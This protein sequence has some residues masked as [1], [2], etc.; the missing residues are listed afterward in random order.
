MH[1]ALAF[2]AMLVLL[3]SWG[4]SWSGSGLGAL[5]YTFGAPILFQYCN[6]IY[7]VGAAWLPLGMHAVDRWVRLGRR[8]GLWE[9]A[10]VLAMQVLGGDPQAAYLLGLAGAAYALGLAWSKAR[11]RTV[12][13][14]AEGNGPRG[15]RTQSILPAF[16][17]I[18]VVLLWSAATVAIGVLLP[19]LRGT[20]VGPPTPPLRWMPWMPM[21]VAMAWGLAGVVFLYFYYWRRRGWRLPL[22]A[23]WLGLVTAAAVAATLAAAQ[24]LPVIE[25]TQLTTRATADGPH[26]FYYFSIEPYR[27]AELIWPN[28]DGFAYGENRF[29]LAAI[30][31]PGVYPSDLGTVALPGSADCHPRTGRTVGAARTTVASVAVGDRSDQLARQPGAIH[32]PDLGGADGCRDGAFTPARAPGRR[33]WSSR[34]SRRSEDPGRRVSQGW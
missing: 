19:K 2:V 3:R 14:I 17:L 9:L 13:Q 22:G 8:W 28:F 21:G 30:R 27:L 7:L 6:V 20:H 24:L 34:H 26:G 31:I 33:A 25:F 12:P 4:I 10:V 15:R 16:G 23:M 1:T 11:A 18:A 32:E 29:W 5:S